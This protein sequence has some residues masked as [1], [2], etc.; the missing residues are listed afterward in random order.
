MGHPAVA[1]VLG[2]GLI[3]WL[4]VLIGTHL[5]RRAAEESDPSA[6]LILDLALVLIVIVGLVG[7]G[8]MAVAV[9]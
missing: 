9:P 4:S 3:V 7:V 6:E 1:E 8:V 5:T 2:G